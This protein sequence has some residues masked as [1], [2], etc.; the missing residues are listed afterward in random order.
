MPNIEI[1][2]N[3]VAYQGKYQIR[4]VELRYQDEQVDEIQHREVFNRGD[5]V[6]AL[7]YNRTTKKL[8]FV[9]Q[10]RVAPYL[11]GHATTFIEV[12]AGTMEKGENPEQTMLREIEEETGYSIQQ[13]EKAFSLYVSPGASTEQIHCFVARFTEEDHLSSGGGLAEEHEHIVNVE[14]TVEE[15]K[16]AIADGRLCDAKSVALVQYALLHRII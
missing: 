11:A 10:F 5:A 4:K 14:W 9:Q 12:C 1:L 13:I 3:E 6:A 2:N 15:T 16:A 7:L 8:L